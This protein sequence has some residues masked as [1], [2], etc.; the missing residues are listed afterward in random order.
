M[1]RN[2]YFAQCVSLLINFIFPSIKVFLHRKWKFF[3]QIIYFFKSKVVIKFTRGNKLF[4]L[5][6]HDEMIQSPQ[7]TIAFCTIAFFFQ[8]HILAWLVINQ[9]TSMCSSCTR[10][11]IFNGCYLEDSIGSK[12]YIH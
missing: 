7:C 3:L 10:S 1:N 5:G 9:N 4:L 11:F 12:N 8:T 2:I 6:T